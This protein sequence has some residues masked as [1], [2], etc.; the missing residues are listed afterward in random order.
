MKCQECGLTTFDAPLC[1]P[2]KRSHEEPDTY[3]RCLE[4]VLRWNRATRVGTGEQKDR[5]W[6]DLCRA[7]LDLRDSPPAL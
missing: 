6:V 4:L 1:F 2:C 3:T 5:T 7:L